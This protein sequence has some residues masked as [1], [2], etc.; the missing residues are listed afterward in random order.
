[1]SIPV[2]QERRLVNRSD[3]IKF[4]RPLDTGRSVKSTGVSAINVARILDVV[5][6]HCPFDEPNQVLDV[7]SVKMVRRDHV[8]I[9]LASRGA[10]PGVGWRW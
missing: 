5:D 4:S 9:I 7:K 3:Q 8:S 6:R 10:G 2:V 1:M